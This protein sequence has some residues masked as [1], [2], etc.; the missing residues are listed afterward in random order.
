MQPA[1][2]GSIGNP[3]GLVSGRRI[4]RPRLPPGASLEL[5]K[6][7]LPALQ[8]INYTNHYTNPPQSRLRAATNDRAQR[9][10]Q[11]RLGMRDLSPIT[12][13]DTQQ[14]TNYFSLTRR[15]SLVQIQHRPLVNCLQ[16]AI[17]CE[18]GERAGKHFPALLLQ[19][20][21]SCPYDSIASVASR[22]RFEQHRA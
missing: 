5:K 2:A 6:F 22:R 9:W 15:G 10:L 14:K 16:T 1:I 11:Y 12:H 18:H 13:N 19:P 7:W 3:S 17:F 21:R 20:E 4:L 8:Y